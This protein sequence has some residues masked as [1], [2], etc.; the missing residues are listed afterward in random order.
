MKQVAVCGVCDELL[1]PLEQCSDYQF[2]YFGDSKIEK[3]YVKLAHF[4]KSGPLPD[5]ILVGYAGAAGLVACDHLKGQ[6]NSPPI[7]WF[8][9]RS[10]FE[11]EAKRLGVGFLPNSIKRQDILSAVQS[12]ERLFAAL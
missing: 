2:T 3:G 5:L 7:I 10:E 1:A 4:I 11:P 9:D 8:C 6:T 12:F